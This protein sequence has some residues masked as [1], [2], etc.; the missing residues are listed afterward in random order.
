MICFGSNA[1]TAIARRGGDVSGN[2]VPQ[3]VPHGDNEHVVAE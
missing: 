2:V 1:C 3:A